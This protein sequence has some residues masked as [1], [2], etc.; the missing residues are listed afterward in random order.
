[1]N[2]F[3]QNLLSIGEAARYLGVTPTTLRRWHKHGTFVA[4]FISPGKRL[5]YSFA[6]LR[7][8]TQGLVQSAFEWVSATEPTAPLPEW[9]CAT[10]DI[11]K[12]RLERLTHALLQHPTHQAV[13]SLIASAAGEIGNNSY[14]HNLG[15]WPDILGT[16]FAYDLS[17]RTIV[18]ADRGVG[19]LSTLRRVKPELSDD[20]A[21]LELAFTKVITGRAPEHRGNGLKYVRH[22]LAQA[23]AQLDFQSGNARFLLDK[24]GEE[25]RIGLAEP[26][27]RGCF[28]VIRF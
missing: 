6:D 19:I 21:A 13:A 23:G 15:N 22:A 24:S 20:A 1:M 26:P 18:L 8:R 7:L 14:D 4:T 10:S 17:K 25:F 3:E 9:H 5:Y 2:T 27:I 16:F 28:A 11:F 12:A